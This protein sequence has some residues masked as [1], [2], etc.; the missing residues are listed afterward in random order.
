MRKQVII[1]TVKKKQTDC[2]ISKNRK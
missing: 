2:Y 1:E